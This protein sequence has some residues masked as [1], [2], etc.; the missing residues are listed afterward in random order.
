MTAIETNDGE[1]M[2]TGKAS[3]SVDGMQV[4]TIGSLSVA[5]AFWTDDAPVELAALAY[6]CESTPAKKLRYD[7][8]AA[9]RHVSHVEILALSQGSLIDAPNLEVGLLPSSLM[10]EVGRVHQLA[11]D[12]ATG[13]GKISAT[14]DNGPLEWFYPMSAGVK[15]TVLSIDAVW[16][17]LGLFLTWRQNP[18][19]G[20]ALGFERVDVF[21]EIKPEDREVRYEA[22]I[23]RMSR[24][25]LNGDAFARA[26]AR[27]YADGRLILICSNA[28]VGC[29]KNIRYCDYPFATEMALGGKLKVR[30][31]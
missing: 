22:S 21:G 20:R 8:F 10:L 3:V 1:T 15:P 6:A 2:V 11:Y 17:L 26:D 14:R 4:Y 5:T 27:V 29:H 28:N 23:L 12:E 7:E 16:Q 13:E 31:S 19:T 24:S 9:K 25:E 18:G 30:A